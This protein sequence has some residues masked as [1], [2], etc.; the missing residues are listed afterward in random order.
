MGDKNRAS[1]CPAFGGSC[2][3]PLHELN[4]RAVPFVCRHSGQSD[5]ELLSGETQNG[6]LHIR[7]DIA[8][9]AADAFE[10]GG[11]LL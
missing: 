3:R 8:Y 6:E 7:I 4:Y 11:R 1:Q 5:L 2:S 9:I 10:T